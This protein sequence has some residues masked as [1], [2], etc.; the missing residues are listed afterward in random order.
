MCCWQ[1][2]ICY[3]SGHENKSK[4]KCGCISNLFDSYMCPSELRNIIT[5]RLKSRKISHH[6]RS[7]FL[8]QNT[9]IIAKTYFRCRNFR[10]EKLSRIS[11]IPRFLGLRREKSHAHDP[12]KLIHAKFSYRVH[13]RKFLHLKNRLKHPHYRVSIFKWRVKILQISKNCH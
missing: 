3:E 2:S 8:F 1:N 13:P 5:R 7:I 12:R 10:V 11:R 6:F 9:N 4:K